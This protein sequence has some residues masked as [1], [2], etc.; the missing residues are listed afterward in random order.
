M[1]NYIS[2]QKIQVS[3]SSTG[4]DIFIEKIIIKGSDEKAPSVYMQASM[5][6]SELQGNTVMIELLEYFKKYQPRGDVYLIPQCNPIGKDVFIGAGHQGRFDSATGD[7]FN[8]YYYYP[9]I[10]YK[11]FAEKHINSSTTDYKKAF[12]EL[13]QIEIKKEL[14]NEWE[15]SRARRLNLIA[16]EEAQKADFVLDLHTDT[17]AITY[18]YTAEFA[19]ETAEK[20]GYRHT[21]V[22]D[23]DKADGALDEAIFCPWW[24]LS[25]AFKELGRD[26]EV[27]KEGYTLE[28]GSEEYINFEDAKMQAQGV[29]NYLSHKNIIDS[30]FETNLLHKDITHTE[31]SN[32]KH[33]K[34]VEGGLYEWF[35]K[36]GDS[37]QAGEVI[38]QYIQTSA[39]TKKDLKMPYGGTVISIHYTGAVCQGSQLINLAVNS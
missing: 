7:N 15:L 11:R 1:Q 10:D 30:P 21:L 6:A 31:I 12:E 22:I 39:M 18:L 33:I 17:D 26:E 19:K 36:A 37:F 8:R 16:Q 28:L 20:F 23:N 38:G 4:E 35:I 3:Q 25:H 13:L 29:L 14:A 5:H 2:K 34:A 9:K 24:H 27:L 32:Y